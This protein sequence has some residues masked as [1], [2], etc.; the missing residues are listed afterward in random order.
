MYITIVLV[1]LRGRNQA[2]SKDYQSHASVF[3]RRI[4]GNQR[5]GADHNMCI[6]ML[7]DTLTSFFCLTCFFLLIRF[8]SLFFVAGPGS[9]LSSCFLMMAAPDAGGGVFFWCW[10]FLALLVIIFLAMITS[11]HSHLCLMA[12][13][14]VSNKNAAATA[15]AS[16]VCVR[17]GSYSGG[18]MI[19]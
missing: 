6:T 13:F 17:R 15:R 4:P 11:T 7:Y 3:A 18:S 9:G 12:A 14:L 19:V 16:G 1:L 8:A 10:R 2:A 5:T